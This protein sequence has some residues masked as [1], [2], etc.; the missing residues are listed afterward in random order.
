MQASPS[1]HWLTLASRLLL[2]GAIFY[3]GYQLARMI[4]SAPQLEQT[5]TL[6]TEQVPAT[7]DTIDQARA[8]VTEIRSLVP[9]MLAE[10]AAVR[11]S[12]P[13]IVDEVA[14][15]R[16]TIPPILDEVSRVRE[17]LP[18]L[19][20]EAAKTRAQIP[21]ILESIDNTTAVIDQTQQQIPELLATG[22]RLA[23]S[24][25]HTT[26][27]LQ[28]LTPQ[29][30]EE[31]RLTRDKIDPTL[32][33]VELLV[34]DAFGKAQ[35]TLTAADSAGR[36]ASEG[37]VTGLFTG[38][39]KLPFNLLGTIASPIVETLDSDIRDQLTQ[40]DIELMAEAGKRL[41]E[42]KALNTPEYWSNAESGN[43][44]S[45]SVNRQFERDGAQCV[46]ARITFNLADRSTSDELATFCR[47]A[48]GN[49]RARPNA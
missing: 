20:D 16:E 43:R 5:V 7:L 26:G 32:D 14:R 1:I 44:G 2:A 45:I 35:D 38:L 33:R 39:L 46:D 10:L 31:V 11:Q 12:I 3:L 24:V 13:P 8:E 22:N 36:D 41:G 19:L 29:V 15:V 17:S 18:P 40:R 49:W 42:S 28:T 4:D 48:D 34:D 30:L 47:D 6:V 25:D 37:A 9:E 27:Q 23:S 21:V